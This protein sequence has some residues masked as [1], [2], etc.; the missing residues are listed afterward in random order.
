M[1]LRASRKSAEERARRVPTSV[2]LSSGRKRSSSFFP[3][4]DESNST[5]VL[6]L[7][8]DL[9]PQ[10]SSESSGRSRSRP[11]SRRKL[12]AVQEGR[13]ENLHQLLPS[14]FLSSTPLL[15]PDGVNCR[16][17]SGV[18]SDKR[19]VLGNRG[20]EIRAEREVEEKRK[21][22]LLKSSFSQRF[23]A[24]TSCCCVGCAQRGGIARF[25][26]PT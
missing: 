2:R 5:D 11:V 12:K 3:F 25:R 9:K 8:V 1:T 23:R 26:A 19:K 16:C 21:H 24:K 6:P 15:N 20:K 13:L 7:A 17:L 10:T 22:V 14:F 18:R 4:I